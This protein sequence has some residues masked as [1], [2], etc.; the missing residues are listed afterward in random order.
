MLRSW[1]ETSLDLY[2][3][4]LSRLLYPIF[5]HCFL[6]LIAK[7]FSSQAK[8]FLDKFKG[9]HVMLHG[10]EINKLAGISLP[11][12][13]KENELAQAY[14]NNKYRTIVSKTSINLLLYFLHENEAVGGAILIRIINQYLNPIISTT[15]PDKV[16]QEGEAN[17]DEGIP[18]YITKTNEIDKFNEQPVKLKITNGTGVPERKLKLS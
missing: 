15:K 14:R 3:P 5:I 9:D 4:E 6:E 10:L 18:D 1:V 8:R 7:N 16:D 2:K 13:L 12:H 11:E 17:P